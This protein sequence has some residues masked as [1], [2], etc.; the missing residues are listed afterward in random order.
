MN[1]PPAFLADDSRGPPVLRNLEVGSPPEAGRAWCQA[2]QNFIS[3][4]GPA[5]HLRWL[6]IAATEDHR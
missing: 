3:W 5:T 6:P 4:H 2:R 1:A